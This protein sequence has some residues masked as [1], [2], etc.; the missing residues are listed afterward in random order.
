MPVYSYPSARILA[1]VPDAHAAHRQALERGDDASGASLPPEEYPFEA[2]CAISASMRQA[3]QLGYTH[4]PSIVPHVVR[5]RPTLTL[6][7]STQP[8]PMTLR[9]T[10]VLSPM[11]APAAM[12]QPAPTAG[13]SVQ[14]LGQEW[15]VVTGASNRC[16]HW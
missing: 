4:V 6:L 15:L 14:G 12:M 1:F 2:H 9:L 5:P 16:N 13:F 11:S 10:L 8:G 7:P 3:G